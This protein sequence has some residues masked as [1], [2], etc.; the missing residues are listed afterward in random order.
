M[1]DYYLTFGCRYAREEHPTFPDANPDGWV[2]VSAHDRVEARTFVFRTFGA[3]W[4]DL[5]SEETFDRSFYPRGEI[6]HLVAGPVDG[7]GV[8]A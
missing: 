2:R 8:P 4:S 6:A 3:W 1:R 7:E 5:C